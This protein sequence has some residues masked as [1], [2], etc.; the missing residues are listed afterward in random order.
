MAILFTVGH[1]KRTDGFLGMYR[2][3]S[4]RLL[5]GFVGS[6]VSTSISQVSREAD[7]TIKQKKDGYKLLPSIGGNVNF[8]KIVFWR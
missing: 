7:I 3:I 2:G 5:G 8:D 4:A 1:I 6:M